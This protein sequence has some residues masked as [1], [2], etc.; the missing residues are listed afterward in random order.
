[1]HKKI[2]E[3]ASNEQIREFVKDF[4]TML[5]ARDFDL[6]EE[7]ECWLY[8][9]VYG[10]HFN[11]WMLEKALTEMAN[12]DGTTGPKWTLEQTTQVA[13]NH[14]IAFVNF[15]EYDWCYVMN[16]LH[17]DFYGVIDED[18]S[19]YYKLAHKFICDK[20]APEGKAFLYY[21]AMK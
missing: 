11:E 13:K 14:G 18:S 12:E 2:I 8:Q 5:K 3:H 21:K 20:D 9:E 15:N 16:M 10:P 7:A 4:I 6:Y 17:S 1:M 19:M